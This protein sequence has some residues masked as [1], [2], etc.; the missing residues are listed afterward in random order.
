[1]DQSAL[2]SRVDYLKLHTGKSFQHSVRRAAHLLH[3]SRPNDLMDPAFLRR[4]PYK[5]EVGAPTREEYRR[6]FDAV[7]KADCLEDIDEIF[8]FGVC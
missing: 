2:E 4:N 8:Q 7:S 5:I 1:V 6:I 3:Q